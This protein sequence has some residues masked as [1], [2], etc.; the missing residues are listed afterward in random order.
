MIYVTIF[1]LKKLRNLK[2]KSFW[3]SLFLQIYLID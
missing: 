3:I 1:N 2:F